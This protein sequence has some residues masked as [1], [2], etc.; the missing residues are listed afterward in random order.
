MSIEQSIRC[1]VCG[2]QKGE[3]NKWFS[4]SGWRVVAFNPKAKKHLCSEDCAHRMLARELQRVREGEVK[5]G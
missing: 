3:A 1:D 2:R 4:L 5:N